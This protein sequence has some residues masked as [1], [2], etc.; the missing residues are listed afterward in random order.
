MDAGKDLGL[1]GHGVCISLYVYGGKGWWGINVTRIC[2]ECIVVLVV[3]ERDYKR[4]D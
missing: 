4:A 3:V 1:K 2:I